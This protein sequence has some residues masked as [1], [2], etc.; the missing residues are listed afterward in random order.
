MKLIL[1]RPVSRVVSMGNEAYGH[2][3][4]TSNN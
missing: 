1:M 4:V 2:T 3:S